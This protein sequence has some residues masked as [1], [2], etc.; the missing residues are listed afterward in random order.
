[1]AAFQRAADGKGEAGKWEL[2]GGKVESG[3]TR[4]Q[5]LFREIQ[6]ELGVEVVECSYAGFVDHDYPHVSLK[7]HVFRIIQSKGQFTLHEHQQVAWVSKEEMLSIDWADADRVFIER[8]LTKA[9][10]AEEF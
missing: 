1:M 2:P 7:L 6:E 3:E 4:E 5:A 8:Y 9:H 10:S